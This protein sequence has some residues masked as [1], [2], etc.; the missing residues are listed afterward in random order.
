MGFFISDAMAATDAVVPQAANGTVSMLMMVGLIVVF[1][2]LLWRPQ[3]KRA[4][5]HKDL[6]LA[7]QKGDEIVSSGGVLG[8]IKSIGEKH[9][10]MTVSDG[11]EIKIQRS[12]VS[13]VLPKGTIKSMSA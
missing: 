10:E 4:K 2:F 13:T 8:K 12:S 9:I 6:I 5:E 1:Y 7:L 11:V 3:S